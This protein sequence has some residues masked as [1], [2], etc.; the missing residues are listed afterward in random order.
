MS[1]LRTPATFSFPR[2][3]WSHGWIDLPPFAWDESRD[4]LLRVLTLSPGMHRLAEIREGRTG[5]LVIH[6]HG[7]A[8]SPSGATDRS[9]SMEAR[10]QIRHMLRLDESFGEFHALCRKVDGFRWI[11][12]AKA[13]PLLRA[14]DPFEDLVKLICTTN[15]S[16]A[17]TRSMVGRL[18]ESLGEPCEAAGASR[19]AFPTPD[20]IASMPLRF[21]SRT[22]RAGYRAPWI[23]ELAARVASGDLS[24]SRWLD[25]ATPTT[26]IREDLEGI[27]GAGRYV[28]ENMLKLLGRYEGLG[29]DS[30]CRREFYRIHH[31]GRRVT[32]RTIE[33]F[34][35]PFGPWR[36]LALWCDVTRHWFDADGSIAVDLREGK[37]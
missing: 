12:R 30:W 29:L 35:A 22:M 34:Y 26:A 6:L 25:P 5:G 19:K 36:G 9:A 32:D 14:P 28:T 24:L 23:R 31:G 20:K 33:R 17:L 8:G 16:W 11:V 7:P 3:A 4:A 27:R 10:R 21:F 37:F 15:C 13:G 2:T 1:R 18:V